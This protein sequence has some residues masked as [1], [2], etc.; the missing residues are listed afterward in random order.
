M[1][2]TS[3]QASN[4]HKLTAI[5]VIQVLPLSTRC[6]ISCNYS[7]NLRIYH[8]KLHCLICFSSTIVA[9]AMIVAIKFPNCHLLTCNH[10]STASILQKSLSITYNGLQMFRNL[11]LLWRRF[12][13]RLSE[14]PDSNFH[15]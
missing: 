15:T 1:F 11:L 14:A 10:Y 5:V 6:D 7:Y 2:V 9:I 4:V 8:T 3:Q 12:S 13:Q